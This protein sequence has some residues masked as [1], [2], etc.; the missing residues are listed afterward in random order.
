LRHLLSHQSGLL[1]SDIALFFGE[2]PP[3][4]L[5]DE[6]GE[7]PMYAAPGTSFQY[8]NQAYS[9]AGFVAARAAGARYTNRSLSRSFERL[10]QE[11][12]F[13]PVGMRR[14]TLDFERALRSGDHA[15][16]NEYSALSAEMEA[17]QVGFERFATTIAPAGGVWSNIDD[18][19][20]YALLHLSKGINLRGQRVVSEANLEET[21]TPQ[22]PAFRGSYGLGWIVGDSPLGRVVT[23]SGGT[24]GFG[25]DLLLV[26]EQG[27]GVVVLTNRASS[28]AFVQAV[29]RYVVEVLLGLDRAPDDDLLA[30]EQAQRDELAALMAATAEVTPADVAD[31]LGL[32]EERVRFDRRGPDLILRN[33]FGELTL[34]ALPGYPG[35]FLVVGNVL[36]G[37]VAQF[38]TDADGSVAVTVGLPAIEGEEVQLLQPITLAKLQRGPHRHSP[39][40]ST[41]DPRGE[42]QRTVRYLRDCGVKPPRRRALH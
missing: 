6:V 37:A 26:P 2:E 7:I 42:W 9:L 8:Q 41:A 5:I 28:F 27:F 23:H 22:V 29:E 10:M 17:V 11:R 33:E 4:G 19:A 24:A 21:H 34:R 39:Q 14:T 18:M 16:P 13:E 1:R 12:V 30:V 20:R 3:L 32:Y 25:A 38:S 35:A 36:G 15:W 31:F 40:R